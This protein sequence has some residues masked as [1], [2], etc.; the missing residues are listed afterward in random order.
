MQ[1]VGL[2]GVL[3]ILGRKQ[4]AMKNQKAY[5]RAVLAFF[6]LFMITSIRPVAGQTLSGNDRSVG[7]IMLRNIKD[8]IKKKYYVMLR[9]SQAYSS[10]RRKLENSSRSDGSFNL[11]LSPK[12]NLPL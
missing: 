3:L 7:H 9:R 6:S 5:S 11:E 12:T 1:K 2:P 8:E 4:I 10:I